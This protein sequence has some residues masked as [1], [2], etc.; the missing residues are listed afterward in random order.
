MQYV[1]IRYCFAA[2][3]LKIATFALILPIENHTFLKSSEGYMH[4]W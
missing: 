2:I 3:R 4:G 1:K